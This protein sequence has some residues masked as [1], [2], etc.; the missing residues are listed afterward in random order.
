MSGMIAVSS[1]MLPGLAQAEDDGIV[2]SFSEKESRKIGIFGRTVDKAYLC[3]PE[4]DQQEAKEDIRL[5]FNFIAQDMGTD[6]AY[7]YAVGVGYGGRSDPASVD[8]D[9]VATKWGMIRQKFNL[10]SG[11][12]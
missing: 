7:L 6:A 2:G 1:F 9:D 4:A 8:C 10:I 12:Q 5:I 3:E 11:D